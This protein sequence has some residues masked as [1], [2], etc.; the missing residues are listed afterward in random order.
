MEWLSLHCF[1]KNA[2]FSFR[3]NVLTVSIHVIWKKI[4]FLSRFSPVSKRNSFECL[5]G[6]KNTG[7][8]K[9]CNREYVHTPYSHKQFFRSLV[10]YS[11]FFFHAFAYFVTLVRAI[12]T[13]QRC[14]LWLLVVALTV[15]VLVCLDSFSFGSSS[16]TH[17]IEM[18]VHRIM[19]FG[20]RTYG[21]ECVW[22]K[23]VCRARGKFGSPLWQRAIIQSLKLIEKLRR[24]CSVLL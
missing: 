21:H 4:C 23:S 12:T 8:I 5:S 22:C 15:L 17:F 1:L 20:T 6:M 13:A 11:I 19:A 18:R 10:S 3:G 9:R 2:L 7:Y 16:K 14:P 24:L